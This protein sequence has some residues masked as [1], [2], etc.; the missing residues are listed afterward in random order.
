[1]MMTSIT[2]NSGQNPEKKT[3]TVVH[4]LYPYTKQRIRVGEIL[5]YFPKNMY[6][7]NEIIDEVVLETYEKGIHI[8]KDTEELRLAMFAM[9]NERIIALFKSEEWHKDSIST[10]Y[11]LKEELKQLEENFTMDANNDLIMTEDLDDIS[12]HQNDSESK[13]L[14]YDESQEGVKIFLGLDQIE[15]FKDHSDRIMLRKVYYKLPINTSNIVDLYVLGKL[16]FHEIGRIL[17]MEV[18]EVKEIVSFV[19]ETIKNQLD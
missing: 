14:P 12:Y 3:L 7:S 9:L 16:S 6:K 11:M 2:N 5:G 17:N 8:T 15:K 10:G 1:M 18:S 13:E 4:L 19:R